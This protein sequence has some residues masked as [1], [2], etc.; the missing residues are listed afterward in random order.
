MS[1]AVD[2]LTAPPPT[3][4][5]VPSP[6]LQQYIKRMRACG[7]YDYH[8]PRHLPSQVVAAASE[9]EEEGEGEGEGEEDALAGPVVLSP[10]L[11][12]GPGSGVPIP[13]PSRRPPIA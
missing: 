7:G 1:H 2:V 12:Q 3:P 8:D 13:P 5:I 10:L 11:T 6:A 9:S 4:R